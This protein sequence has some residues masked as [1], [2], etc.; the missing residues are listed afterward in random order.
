[1]V[2]IG[3]LYNSISWMSIWLLVATMIVSVVVG[4]SVFSLS[5]IYYFIGIAILSIL[6][7]V[8]KIRNVYYR[9]SW[10]GVIR[11]FMDAY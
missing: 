7:P 9:S 1:M 5:L 6:W 11:G 3:N 2:E 4:V 8:L 10:L